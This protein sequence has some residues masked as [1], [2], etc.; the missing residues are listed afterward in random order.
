MESTCHWICGWTD[1]SWVLLLSSLLIVEKWFRLKAD[2]CKEI[3][4]LYSVYGWVERATIDFN[5]DN[6]K[7]SGCL[8]FIWA[9]CFDLMCVCVC[10]YLKYL[11]E[12]VNQM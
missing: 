12:C 7:I 1:D 8:L 3:F 9:I 4:G 2:L 10:V 5:C 11:M 6:C